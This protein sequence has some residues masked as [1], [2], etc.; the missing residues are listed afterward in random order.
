MS[1]NRIV[2]T[3]ADCICDAEY[4]I[5]KDIE[6]SIILAT[7]KEKNPVALNQFENILNNISKA[8]ELKV[9]ICQDTGIPVIYLTLPPTIPYTSEIYNAISD[10]VKLAT[11]LVPLRPNVVNPITRVN[12]MDNTGIGMP[13]IHVIP[14]DVFKVTVLPKGAGSENMSQIRMMLPSQVSEIPKF[15]V[16]TV[17]EAGSKPCPPIIVGVGIGG[18]FDSVASLS[19]EALLM[20]ID[21]MD[22]CEQ[23]ICN[24]INSL[25]I[26]PMGLGGNTTALAV[27]IKRG[28]CHTA[29]LPVA[30]NIQCWC[31]R[32]STKE[33]EL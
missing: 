14:G 18:T 32:H 5:P 22:K 23:N 1:Y 31:C 20:P 19:K 15:I 8:R 25:G 11:K 24:A 7:K 10:G 21:T 30:I 4:N 12:T 29:S 33:V 13:T 27:K 26:G 9:P 6:Q 2:Q 28:D 16:D 17:I 3:V